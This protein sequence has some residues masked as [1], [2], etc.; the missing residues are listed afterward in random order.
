MTPERYQQIDKVFQAAIEREPREREAFLDEACKGDH[1]LRLEVEALI[2]SY[3]K[4]GSFIEAPI[5]E[6]AA[7]LVAHAE[8]GSL[9]GRKVGPIRS[10]RCLGREGWV[11]YISRKM[12]VSAGRWR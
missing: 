11:K 5:F 4:A 9:I 12:A 1:S 2:D 10:Q 3:E 7:E 8:I 6:G